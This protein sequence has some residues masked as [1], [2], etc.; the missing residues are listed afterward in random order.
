MTD[1]NPQY[2]TPRIL[3]DAPLRDEDQA[4]FHFDKFA[5]TLAR[6]V[7]STETRT[8][9]TVGISGPW[10]S[11]KT[12]LLKRVQKLLDEGQAEYF[13]PAGD[14]RAGKT[15]WFEAWKYDDE[16]VLDYIKTETRSST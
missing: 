8:P 3:H 15:V 12:T 1:P 2:E 4:D 16:A 7:A 11:G 6:L 10:G 13:A 5:I 14:F 9:L